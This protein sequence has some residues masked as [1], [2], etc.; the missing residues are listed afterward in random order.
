MHAPSDL[1]DSIRQLFHGE[2]NVE[3]PSADID[4][5]DTG[6]LD[7]LMLVDLLMQLERHFQIQMPVD[8]IDVE[9]FRT[10][11]L[12]AGVVQ[13]YQTEVRTA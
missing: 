8:E 2:L 10:L 4:I 13:R 3:I 1:I 6:L 5:I 9:E 11:Q 12:I 7:S